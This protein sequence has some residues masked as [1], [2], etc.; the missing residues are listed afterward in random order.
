MH[1]ST[2]LS[3]V[4]HLAATQNR[5]FP[6]VLVGP[7]DD[8]AVL[9]APRGDQLLVTV[10]HV[11]EGRHVPA[12]GLN[13][14]ATLL[15]LVA[16]KTVARSLSDLAAMAGSPLAC[17]VTACLPPEF[18]QLAAETLARRLHA[19]GE[20]FACPVV[21]GDIASFAKAAPGPVTLTLTALGLAHPTRGPVL[22]SGAQVGDDVYVT[23]ALGGS[24]ASDGMGRHLTF[25][26]RVAEGAALASAL[27]PALHAM[28]D[29]SDGLGVDAARLAVASHVDME[30]DAGAIPISPAA[31]DLRGAISDGE[32]YE[33]LFAVAPGAA[34][35]T[36]ATPIT[37]IGRVMPGAGRA[38]LRSPAGQT[39]ISTSGWLHGG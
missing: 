5:R 29:L 34:M 2:L 21:G 4:Q 35:P 12:L 16:R 28:M 33:L 22:R 20:H 31:R 37:R 38:L 11:V 8:C 27:G 1:E 25:E 19:W 32:D 7:G 6:Q 30:F 26:P 13:P 17:V 39:D 36:L 10:D 9:A 14:D 23:G 24:L 15:D 18:A 3:M